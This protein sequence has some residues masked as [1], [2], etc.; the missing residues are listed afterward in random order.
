M[1]RKSAAILCSA[2][3]WQR[4]NAKLAKDDLFMMSNPKTKIIYCSRTHSQVSQMVQS[5]KKTPYRPKMAILGSRDRMCIHP[6]LR[7][8]NTVQGGDNKWKV[9]ANQLNQQCR[10]RVQNTEKVRNFVFD[11]FIPLIDSF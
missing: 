4:Y 7:P 11:S 10:I 3:A 5:L 1:F 6:K 8:R 9:N 2:L